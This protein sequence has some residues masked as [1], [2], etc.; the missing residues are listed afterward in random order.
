MT[1]DAP[2]R[3]ERLMAAGELA[4]GIGSEEEVLP[5]ILDLVVP[6]IAPEC[7][8]HQFRD[9][10]LECIAARGAEPV[11]EPRAT[12]GRPCSAQA[13]TTSASCAPSS[14]MTTSPGRTR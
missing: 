8:V 5:R 12:K 10:R 11:P 13:R 1:L 3:L 2:G 9:G 4:D 6:G 7:L 14:G